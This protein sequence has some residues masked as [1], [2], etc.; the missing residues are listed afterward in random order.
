MALTVISPCRWL[1]GP[2][3]GRPTMLNIDWRP[4]NR[5][6]APKPLPTSQA[7]T[8]LPT[9]SPPA[10]TSPAPL[11]MSRSLERMPLSLPPTT[12]SLARA[13]PR[14]APH[15]FVA[16]D[17]ALSISPPSSL[18]IPSSPMFRLPLLA[19]LPLFMQAVGRPTWHCPVPQHHSLRHRRCCPVPQRHHHPLRS[20]HTVPST[21]LHMPSTSA[22]APPATRLAGQ[23]FLT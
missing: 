14:N 3:V 11:P 21:L 20:L 1:A 7:S 19:G 13:Y 22:S 4:A 8:S 5:A 12:L 6:R 9:P 2:P 18:P 16:G 10:R 23:L 15:F 17:G